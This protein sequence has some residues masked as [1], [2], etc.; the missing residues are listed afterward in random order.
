MVRVYMGRVARKSSVMAAA[1]DSTLDAAA[2][3]Q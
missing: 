2:A 1:A 3:D